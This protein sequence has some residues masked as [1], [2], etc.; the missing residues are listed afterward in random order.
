MGAACIRHSLRPLVR[1]G[2]LL[3]KARA[4]PAA[5]MLDHVF[6]AVTPRACGESNIPEASRFNHSR[7]WNTEVL[8]DIR[9]RNEFLGR[10][11]QASPLRARSRTHYHRRF[12]SDNRRPFCLKMDSAVWVLAFARTTASLVNPPL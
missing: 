7:L 11:G 2:R 9:I 6:S 5:R 3:G 12:S 4:N 1:K 10:P 8:F